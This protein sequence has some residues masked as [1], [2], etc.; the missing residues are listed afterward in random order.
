MTPAPTAATSPRRRLLGPLAL[1]LMVWAGFSPWFPKLASPNELTRVYLAEALVRDGTVCIDGPIA[2]HGPVF[3]ASERQVDGVARR[4]SDKAPGVALLALPGV[5]V[6]RALG[7]EDLPTLVAVTRLLGATL[8]ALWLLLLVARHLPRWLPRPDLHAALLVALALASPLAAYGGLAFGHALSATVLFALHDRLSALPPRSP[9]AL[10]QPAGPLLAIGAL[11]GLAVLVEYQNA[12][13][14]LPFAVAFAVQ[15]RLAPRAVGL[16]LL[17]AVPPALVFGLYHQAAFGSP[18]LTGYSF[19]A[20]SFAAV[21][22]QGLLGVALPRL[23]HAWLGFFSTEK[24][25]FFFAPWLLLGV[26]SLPRLLRGAPAQAEAGRSGLLA[27][28]TSRR[29][30]AAFLLLIGLFVSAMVYPAGGWTV[31]QRHLTPALP[32]LTLAVAATLSCVANRFP[33]IESVFAGLALPAL[34]TCG[35]SALL[36][37]HWQDSLSNPAWQLAPG[38]LAD[39]WVP[40]SLLSPHVPSRPLVVALL[41]LAA[42]G[43]VA[44]L[45]RRDPDAPA[46]PALRLAAAALV[47]AALS[48]WATLPGAS[49]PDLAR[50]R[51]FIERTYVPDPLATP[52][53]AH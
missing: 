35:L 1:A 32:F 18:F 43:L 19:I 5:A 39:G 31:S 15:T 49:D 37:P 48:A 16:A 50:E 9:G 17:G 27:D 24:G 36:W 40:P 53:R 33:A 3:D 23:D 42:L 52:G 26:F 12:L 21:H 29:L 47:A 4:F 14:L 34:V 41:T 6:A 38:L 2:R 10:P 13:L 30:V 11:A 51:R 20:T 44:P 22:A 46:L 25:L 8:P 28:V 45:L 7:H